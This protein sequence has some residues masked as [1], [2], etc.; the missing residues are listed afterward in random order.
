MAV[1]VT[2]LRLNNWPL[3]LVKL[4]PL[5]PPVRDPESKGTFQEKL[6]ES[7]TIPFIPLVGDKTK[8]NPPQLVK[9]IALIEGIGFR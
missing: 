7:G 9:V 1:C 4:A 6:I 2:L 3:M 8:G 5:L